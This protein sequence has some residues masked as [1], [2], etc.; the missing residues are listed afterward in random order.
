MGWIKKLL[1]FLGLVVVVLA[2]VGLL[3][4]AERHLERTIE[5]DHP[6]NKVFPWINSLHAFNTWSPWFGRDPK[7][8]YRFE[9]PD[10]GVGARQSWSSDHPEVGSG[11]QEIIESRENESVRT[12]LHFAEQGTAEA[13]WTL[14][15]TEGG[16]RVVWAF[17]TDFGFNLAGRYVGLFLESMLGPDYEQGLTNLKQQVESGVSPPS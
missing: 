7:A 1:I 3:L 16:T 2:G 12:R 17:D 6:P 14:Q 9:G 11:S 13:Q 10:S 15:P 5:I 8:D 4:P